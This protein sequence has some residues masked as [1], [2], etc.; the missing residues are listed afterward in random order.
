MVEQWRITGAIGA[1]IAATIKADG[2]ELCALQD[3]AGHDLLWDAGPVW[4]SHSPVLFPIVG[5]VAGDRLRIDDQTYALT[6][7]GF[8]R[9]RRFEWRERTATRC[10][11][12]LRDDETTRAVYPFPFRLVLTYVIEDGALRVEYELTNSGTEMMPASLGAHPAFRW[13]LHDG[14]Q[15]DYRLEFD[16]D[17]PAP[18]HR[19][20]DGLLDPAGLP[21]PIEGRVLPLDP[22][23][24]LADAIIMLEPRSRAVRYVGPGGGLEFCWNGFPQLGLWQKPGGDFICIE[25]WHGHSSPV[26]WDGDFRDKPG[27]MLVAPGETRSFSWSVRPIT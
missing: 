20:T 17:E 26:G 24:F 16:V 13:P 8:A 14:V 6:R 7:H 2:A 1:K 3:G 19:V 4:P 9:R 25:P 23:L 21:S 15:T 10:S 12:E 5:Q 11:L 27:V 22:K 18:I